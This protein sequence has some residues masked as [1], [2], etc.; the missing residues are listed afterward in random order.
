MDAG[1]TTIPLLPASSFEESLA[2]WEALGFEVTYRQKAPNA[3]P[4][5]PMYA[6]T[7]LHVGTKSP[8]R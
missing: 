6:V 4:D 7:Y 1:A 8:D 5:S 3:Q 2:F